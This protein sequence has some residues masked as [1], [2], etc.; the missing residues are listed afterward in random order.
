[1]LMVERMEKKYM[2]KEK[3]L[4]AAKDLVKS[5]LSRSQAIQR[6]PRKEEP[7]TKEKMEKKMEKD[8]GF[9][10]IRKHS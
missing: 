10:T 2:E 5:V 7:Q 3:R 9:K 8:E 1:M 6:R 4:Q